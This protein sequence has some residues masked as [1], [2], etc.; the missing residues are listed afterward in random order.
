MPEMAANGGLLQ[1]GSRSPGSGFGHLQSQIADSLRRIFE[2]FPFFGDGDW[3]PGSIR[4]CVV[5]FAVQFA[6][7]SALAAGKLRLLT[8]HCRAELALKLVQFSARASPKI[9]GCLL[10]SCKYRGGIMGAAR[11]CAA[12]D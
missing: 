4:H 2:I 8:P 5:Q 7:F 1:I 9:K 3:R 10:K 6:K 11:H 12:K